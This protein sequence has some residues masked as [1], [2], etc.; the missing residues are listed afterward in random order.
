MAN[1]IKIN[2]SE[3]QKGFLSFTFTFQYDSVFL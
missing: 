1:R 2:V 3:T